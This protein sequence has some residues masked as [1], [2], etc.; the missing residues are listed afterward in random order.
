MSLSWKFPARK[1][2]SRFSLL[3][4][5][6]SMGIVCTGK[7]DLGLRAANLTRVGFAGHSREPNRGKRLASQCFN[8][9]YRHRHPVEGV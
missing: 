4:N 1:S 2:R 9:L 8:D 6:K 7:S 3:L 5:L